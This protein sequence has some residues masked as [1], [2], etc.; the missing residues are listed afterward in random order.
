[1]AA[2]TPGGILKGRNAA[3][4]RTTEEG[5]TRR[6]DRKH[7][8]RCADPGFFVVTTAAY[9]VAAALG[10]GLTWDGAYYLFQALNTGQAFGP[11]DRLINLPLQ[12]PVIAAR[13]VIDNPS[14]LCRVIPWFADTAL[15]GRWPEY[16]ALHNHWLSSMGRAHAAR[17]MVDGTRVVAGPGSETDPRSPR[18]MCGR[19]LS[20][21]TAH[22]LADKPVGR[23]VA[24]PFEAGGGTH[25]RRSKPLRCA[26]LTDLEPPANS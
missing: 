17:P 10:L 12:Q 5:I 14:V 16:T 7:R 22:G 4:A 8:P 13:A 20:R 23:G 6:V 11:R 2:A 24:R 26:P 3:S 21:A 1:M 15:D 19:L 9:A 25:R 18:Y